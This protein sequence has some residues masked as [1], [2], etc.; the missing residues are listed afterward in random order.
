MTHTDSVGAEGTISPDAP[1]E[2]EK[3]SRS[4]TRVS[5]SCSSSPRS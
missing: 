2:Q 5:P 3:A 4:R 1:L